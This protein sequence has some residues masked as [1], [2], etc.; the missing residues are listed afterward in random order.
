MMYTF[1]FQLS[2][3]KYDINYPRMRFF[4]NPWKESVTSS[5]GAISWDEIG[6]AFDIPAGAVAAGEQV[7]L[8]VWPATA[9]PFSLPDG[10]ELASPVYQITPAYDFLCNITIKIYHFCS[11]T[12]DKE[13][14]SMAFLSS[15][16]SPT[17]VEQK[18]IYTFKILSKGSFLPSNPCGCV[19]LKH[20][21]NVGAGVKRKRTSSVPGSKRVKGEVR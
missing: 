1:Y 5:G 20:F 6:I 15:S 8:S 14:D 21:C 10:Y 18:P 3:Y 16:T 11:L 2:G 13:C 9:G 17:F 12:I 19:S 4:G 7:D